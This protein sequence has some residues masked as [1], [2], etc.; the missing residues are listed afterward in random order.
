MNLCSGLVILG[1]GGHARSVADVALDSGIQQLCFVDENARPNERFLTFAVQ[2]EW[3]DNLP[4]GWAVIAASGDGV[5]REAQ[6]AEVLARGWA[7]A[8]VV[9]KSATLCIGVQVGEGSFVGRH[10][11]IGPMAK[12]GQGC[13][14]NTAAIIEHESV[15]GDFTHVS[16]NTTVAG[17]STIGSHCF[18][19]AGATVVDGVAVADS[20]TVGAGACV[21]RSL[22]TPGTYVGVPAR[23]VGGKAQ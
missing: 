5:R 13:I 1:F 9:A 16:V 21:T 4:E 2:R 7:L 12:V 19:G 18:I 8:T 20:I 15:V 14:I 6:G 23:P 11:H 3:P 17:R 22:D 10:A